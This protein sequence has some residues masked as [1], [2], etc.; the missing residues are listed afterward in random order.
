MNGEY[1]PHSTYG[2]NFII[3]DVTPSDCI[4]Y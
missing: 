2:I 1:E 3:E 4:E